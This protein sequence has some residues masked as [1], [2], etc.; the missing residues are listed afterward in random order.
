[1]SNFDLN[2]STRPFPAYRLLNIALACILVVLGVL[3]VWQTVGFLRYSRLA[4]SIRTEEQETR[5]E[6]EVLGKRVV[7]LESRLD[8][9]E[10][11]AK[12]SE[13]GFLNRLILRK[14]FSWTRL[15]ANL[16]G[17]VPDNVHLVSLAPN[18][19]ADGN[20]TLHISLQGRSIADV[21]EFI[22]RLEKSPVFEKIVVTAEEKRDPAVATDVDI[23]L[24]AVYFPLRDVR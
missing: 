9:P 18:I 5:V 17:M 22:E 20:I 2:L 3:S 13:I 21:T 1:M 10:A 16:E 8:R 7:E 4:R 15:F 14:N 19:G 11:T 24:S 12:L 23:V 6:A